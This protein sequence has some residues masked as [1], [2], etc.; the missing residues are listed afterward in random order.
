M[1]WFRVVEHANGVMFDPLG[2]HVSGRCR[3]RVSR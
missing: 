2:Q 3:R 1:A